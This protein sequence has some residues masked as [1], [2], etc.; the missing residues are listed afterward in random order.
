VSWNDFRREGHLLRVPHH[1]K[2]RAWRSVTRRMRKP[3]LLY[4]Q[5]Y[6]L[7]SL[8]CTVVAFV[9]A[10]ISGSYGVDRKIETR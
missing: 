3:R 10:E 7:E 1:K 2:S 6:H 9:I 5:N 8:G 4:F